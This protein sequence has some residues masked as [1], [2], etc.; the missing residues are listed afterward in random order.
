[1]SVQEEDEV[2]DQRLAQGWQSLESGDVEAA[3]AAVEACAED[4]DES[5]RLESLMLEAA[6]ERIRNALAQ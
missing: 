3:R 2:L 1:M 6:C 5:V 4:K